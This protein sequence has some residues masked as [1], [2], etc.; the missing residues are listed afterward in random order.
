[1][2]YG[3]SGGSTLIGRCSAVAS[4][5]ASAVSITTTHYVQ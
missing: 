1:M 5:V 4:D 3:G 2:R